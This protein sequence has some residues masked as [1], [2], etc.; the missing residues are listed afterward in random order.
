MTRKDELLEKLVKTPRE[1]SDGDFEE[2]SGLEDFTMRDLRPILLR[3]FDMNSGTILNK[4]DA[5]Q[6]FLGSLNRRSR[7]QRNR[8]FWNKINKGDYTKI[9]LVEGDSWF[10]YPLFIKD[11][12][13]H[14]NKSERNYA[15]YSLAYGGDWLSNIL[16]EHE[17]IE[18]LSLLKPDVFLISGG[19]NDLVGGRRLAKLVHRR[20]DITIDTTNGLE[21]VEQRRQFADQCLNVEFFGLL[22]LLELQYK[23]LFKSI[24]ESQDARKF[25][26]L[27]I[28]TQGYD[29]AIPSSEKGWGLV[30]PITNWLMDNGKWLR[31]PLMLRGYHDCDEQI[32]IVMGM[33]SHLNDMLIR[34]GAQYQN[35]CH[36]DSRGS[37]DPKTGWYNE[38]H[39]NSKEFK[40]IAQVFQECI[41]AEP[42]TTKVFKWA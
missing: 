24:E 23:L 7:D 6:G 13:D 42:L 14:L 10:E 25:Q 36:I 1:F 30:R 38:L 37:V 9:I 12:V 31:T 3:I 2:L 26:G 32:S 21:T 19:G 40:K 15:I 41:E 22:K 27:R 18:E 20:K 16:Y 11:I 35:V 8:R 5:D 4:S 34:V 39:P 17:Y 28:I 33:I 29:Y